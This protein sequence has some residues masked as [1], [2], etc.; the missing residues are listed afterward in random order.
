MDNPGEKKLK[1]L[2]IAPTPF[3]ADRGCHVKILE[4]TR[5]LGKRNIAVKLVTYHIG[6]NIGEIDI[7]RI[8]KIPWYKKLEAGPS[9]HKYYL[10]LIL[11][12]KTL[13]A[14]RRFKPDILHAH[15][16]EGVF[17]AKIVGL[18][19]GIPI[20]ADYQGSMIGEMMDHGF[21]RKNSFSYK[22]NWWLENLI[23]RWPDKIVFSST[24]AK[25][26]FLSNFKVDPLKV[27]SFVEGTNTDEFHPGY[28]VT[29]LRKKLNLPEGKKIVI[30]LGVLT[31]YQGVDLLIR[32]AA[33]ILKTRSDVHFLIAGFPSVDYYSDMAAGLGALDHITFT[34]KVSHEEVP[35]YLNL[36]DIGVSLKLSRTEANGKLF[37]YMAV[38]LPCIV[39][40]TKTNREI[41]GDTGIYAEY[42]S[43]QSF[44]DKLSYLL[45]N[46]TTAR[47][48]GE[49][50]RKRVLEKYTWDNTFSN[51]IDIYRE[52][53]EGKMGKKQQGS[54]Q[55]E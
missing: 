27:V 45:D 4:E 23:N 5:A 49:L 51:F 54:I 3:F 15:L 46:E 22:F 36:A 55:D 14:A 33:E 6:R 16:H 17:V 10:D 21:V 41:L 44:L 47:K 43:M 8:I 25:D 12:A 39:F 7:E 20:I 40:D 31:K 42:N 9:I 53:M 29:D 24:Q 48:Y 1:I 32:S 35:R 37:G 30:Y 19:T 26:F 38:G 28:D 50:A 13:A 2:M 18:F 11:A 52:V 34:G